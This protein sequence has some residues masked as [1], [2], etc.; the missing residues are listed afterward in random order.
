LIEL[1]C[2]IAIIGLLT[3]LLLGPVAKAL[4]KA[5]NA[6]WADKAGQRVECVVTSLRQHYRQKTF[7]DPLTPEQL[8]EQGI[9]DAAS[10]AFLRDRRVTYYPFVTADADQSIILV[11]QVPRSFLNDASTERVRKERITAPD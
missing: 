3:S 7:T 1:L 9:I 2:V 5:C 6:E 8:H 11:V 10:L 4:Q